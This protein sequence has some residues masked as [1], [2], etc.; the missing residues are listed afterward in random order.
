VQARFI[1]E[2]TDLPGDETAGLVPNI[3]ATTTGQ[4]TEPS[5]Q[6]ALTAAAALEGGAQVASS[7]RVRRLR[8][9]GYDGIASLRLATLTPSSQMDPTDLD[10]LWRAQLATILHDKLDVSE[11]KL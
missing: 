10:A 1:K 8:L 6:G 4:L 7:E 2:W 9:A 3:A 5:G 11:T